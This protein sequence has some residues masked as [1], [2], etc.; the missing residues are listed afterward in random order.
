MRAFT[1]KA[2]KAHLNELVESAQ[3]GEQV[4]LMC[5]AKHVAAI[6]PINES[7]LEL[8]IDLADVQAARLW[9]QLASEQASGSTTMFSSAEKA[10]QHLSKLGPERRQRHSRV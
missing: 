3:A 10:V 9:R 2:A 8:V 4:V 5:G 6:I 1:I 7:H